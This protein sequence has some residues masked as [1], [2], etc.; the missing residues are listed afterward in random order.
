MSRVA[1][2]LLVAALPA[3]CVAHDGAPTSGNPTGGGGKA[4]GYGTT[5]TFAGDFTQA[6]D[7][8]LVAGSSIHIAYDLDRL[9][10]CRAESGGSDQW[11]VTGWAQF[12]AGSATPFALSRLDPHGTAQPIVAG[13]DIP[14]TAKH[15]QLW[16][17]ESNVYGCN[18]YDSDDSANYQFDVTHPASTGATLA[19]GSDDGAPVV[20]GSVHAGG[21]VT[22]HYEPSR[23]A[24]CS[25]SSGGHAAW[26]VTGHY[27][28]DGGAVH[29]LMVTRADGSDL[30]ASDAVFSAP[31]GHDLA[32][33]FEATSVWGCHAYD[34]A[35]GA[36]YHVAIE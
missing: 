23:L 18:A 9:T 2:W 28:V 36:N 14:R 17:S 10:A 33:W 8:D 29:D 1:V 3:A 13:L 7:G 20:T 15:L 35:F 16:F 19:F 34:S 12:D 6:A 25:G 21:D 27:Q 32:L 26:G 24:T 5:I 30:V 11:G 22:V 4:D 31:R